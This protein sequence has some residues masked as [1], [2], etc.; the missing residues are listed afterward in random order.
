MIA[1]QVR[2]GLL[3]VEFPRGLWERI[4]GLEKRLEV[5]QYRGP[6]LP[7]GVQFLYASTS[8]G[9]AI[10]SIPVSCASDLGLP[11]SARASAAP[12]TMAAE[13]IQNARS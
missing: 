4:A 5:G 12:I 6:A 7:D 2:G 13:L 1:D 3:R 9:S 11:G 10:C 8:S